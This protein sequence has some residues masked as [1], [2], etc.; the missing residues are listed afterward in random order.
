M[1]DVKKNLIALAER[2]GFSQ[3]QVA[4]ELGITQQA[5]SAWF[6]RSKGFT[7]EHL[8]QVCDII[9][10]SVVDVITY[11]AKYIDSATLPQECEECRRKQETIDNLNEY[12][13]LLKSKNKKL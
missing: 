3:K 2:E 5:Y 13:R 6:N 9:N 8:E 11:P 1:L 7:L 4:A 12:I 10:V